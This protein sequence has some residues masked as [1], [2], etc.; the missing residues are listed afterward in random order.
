MKI[1]LAIALL[2]LGFM[3][4]QGY[5]AVMELGNRINRLAER[6]L[7]ISDDLDA[8]AVRLNNLQTSQKVLNGRMSHMVYLQKKTLIRPK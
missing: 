4:W 5:S 2:V 3:S 7:R 1:F 6:N 8:L